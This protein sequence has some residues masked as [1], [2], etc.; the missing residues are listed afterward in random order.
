MV[1]ALRYKPSR[2][3]RVCLPFPLF[4]WHRR[5]IAIYALP[6]YGAA[7]CCTVSVINGNS[8][9]EKKANR[10]LCKRWM[11]TG[12]PR[13]LVLARNYIGWCSRLQVSLSETWT[14]QRV[15]RCKIVLRGDRR[16]VSDVVCGS[17]ADCYVREVCLFVPH[18]SCLRFFVE[19]LL[20]ANWLTN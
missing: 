17:A 3:A 9:S 5:L 6:L 2:D 14:Q 8:E 19:F 20:P 13:Q 16:R 10:I 7:V 1:E 18:L 15:S 4:L 12:T 11:R